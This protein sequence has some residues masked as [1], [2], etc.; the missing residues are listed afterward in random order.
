MEAFFRPEDV[1]IKIKWA[2][3]ANIFFATKSDITTAMLITRI[4]IPIDVRVEMIGVREAFA[5]VITGKENVGGR[6]AD[7]HEKIGC[8]GATHVRIL[9]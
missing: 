8:D 9:L 6:L 5:S 4:R 2:S 7:S 1:R 3:V